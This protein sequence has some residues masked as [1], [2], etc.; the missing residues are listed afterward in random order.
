MHITT[1]L[2]RLI[3][4]ECFLFHRQR[5][6]ICASSAQYPSR[7]RERESYVSK[8]ILDPSIGFEDKL[9][10]GMLGYVWGFWFRVCKHCGTSMVLKNKRTLGTP[11]HWGHRAKNGIASETINC[12]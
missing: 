8:S 4:I 3:H 10:W 6:G 12:M 11:T 2:I 5:V 1:N 7:D 9:F